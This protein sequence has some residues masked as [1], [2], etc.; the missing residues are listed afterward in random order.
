MSYIQRTIIMLASHLYKL[1]LKVF[2]SCI[3]LSFLIT[4]SKSRSKTTRFINGQ[5]TVWNEL[6]N[7]LTI[8]PLNK[9]IW[10]HVASLG[11]FAIIRPIISR[12]KSK[13]NIIITFFSPSGYDIVKN[14]KNYTNVFYLPIDCTTNAHRFIDL[15]KPD[16]AVFAVSELWYN[17][18]DILNKKQI[19]CILISS[20]IRKD[21]VYFK[22][23]GMLHRHMLRL[24]NHI[25]TLSQESCYNLS[26]LKVKAYSLSGDPLFDNAFS[27]A[28]RDYHNIIVENF[29]EKSPIFIA[30]SIDDNK[31]LKLV[32]SL[33]NSYPKTKFLIVPH[34]ISKEKLNGI[35]ASLDGKSVLYSDCNEDTDF[36]NVQALII[37]YIGDLPYL[38]RYGTWAYVGGGFTPYLH[39]I[40]E[41]VVY[42]IPV[43]FGPQIKRKTTPK[44]LIDLGIGTCVRNYTELNNWFRNLK[45]SP[46]ELHFIKATARDYLN[47]NL[48]T[49]DKIVDKILE[50]V[51]AE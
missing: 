50:L 11:E 38:Y 46:E 17:Y 21:S 9:T 36:T 7:T 40:I 13:S 39:S 10:F 31:D 27:N 43:S 48:G 30:G 26:R 20:I 35:I 37:D 18:L 4:K 15:I 25:F 33:A 22:T 24:F 19:P 2:K 29:K 23:Y 49:T 8:N 3:D 41:P 34:A 14:D 42:G 51:H 28:N 1:A 12:I 5:G 16:L 45:D 6:L 32:S 47:S 44:Q